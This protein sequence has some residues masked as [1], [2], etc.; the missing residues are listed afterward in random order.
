[1]DGK[2]QPERIDRDVSL[3]PRD[4]LAS[5]VSAASTALACL[6]ALA[7]DTCSARLQFFAW[8]FEHADRSDKSIVDLSQS[9]VIPPLG[10]VI[11]HGAFGKEVVRNH[12]PLASASALVENRVEHLP[13][14]DASRAA[15]F[16]ALA[17]FG[18]QFADD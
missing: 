11:V 4:F 18:D 15:A 17:R 1:R 2:Q 10:E 3:S 9:P 6:D 14:I 5:I 13:H 16:A 12:V 8:C 7:V